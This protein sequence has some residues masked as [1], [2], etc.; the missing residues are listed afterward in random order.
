MEEQKKK[1]QR[2]KHRN[3][4]DK[5]NTTGEPNHLAVG[6]ML[7]HR[8]DSNSAVGPLSKARVGSLIDDVTRHGETPALL[9]RLIARHGSNSTDTIVSKA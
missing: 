5:L 9:R 8:G 3:R 6:V 2:E 7:A 1:G 4:L